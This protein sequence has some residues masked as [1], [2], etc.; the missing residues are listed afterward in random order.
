MASFSPVVIALAILTVVSFVGAIISVYRRSILFHGYKELARDAR[1]IARTFRGDVYRDGNDLVI[2]GN[3]NQLPVNVRFSQEEN[4][5]GLFIRMEMPALF[6]L[7]IVP[8]GSADVGE[9]R[10]VVRIGDK[11]FDNR[12]TTRT[13]QPTQ[14]RM[15]LGPKVIA[16]VQ[17]LCCSSKTFLNIE[18]GV[19][20]LTELAIP[21]AYVARHVNEHLH[22]MAEIGKEMAEMPGAHEI[23]IKPIEIERNVLARVAI[24]IGVV[25]AIATVAVGYTQRQQA[26]VALAA[27]KAPGVEPADA[28]II[29][30]TQGW[31]LVNPAQ[32]FAG[33]GMTW[34]SNNSLTLSGKM[35]ADFSGNGDARDDLY[36]LRRENGPPF[37]VVLLSR[38][39]NRYDA[40]YD[41]LVVVAPF[42]KRLVQDT[43][44]VG[45]APDNPDGDGLLIAFD[46]ANPA[47]TVVIFL[48]GDRIISGQPAHYENIQY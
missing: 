31:Q 44:W 47:N 5:P 19:M 40:T 20:E 4:T 27:T 11:A 29:P 15:L 7:T 9:G 35:T 34:A 37:R 32:D 33:P 23:K 6:H 42:P 26:P 41:K 21:S 36:V 17:K 30:G 24:G 3:M 25:A 43:Q 46:P 16:N 10:T 12:F 1:D 39:Q 14:F 2:S 48:K 22:Q 13:D 8:Q 18:R 28:R 38:G 45:A